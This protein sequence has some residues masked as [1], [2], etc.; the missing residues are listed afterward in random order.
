M[1]E[2]NTY[3]LLGIRGFKVSEFNKRIGR[4]QLKAKN[5]VTIHSLFPLLLQG[6]FLGIMEL[7]LV[8][9]EGKVRTWEMRAINRAVWRT[10]GDPSSI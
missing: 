9:R 5:N 7:S 8:S 1:G 4:W 6:S 2:R 10:R 3:R